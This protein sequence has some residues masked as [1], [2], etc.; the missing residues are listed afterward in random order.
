LVFG[1]PHSRYGQLPCAQIILKEDLS[2]H[3]LRA[4]C[5]KIL[6]PYKVPKEFNIV[7]ELS[8]TKSGKLVR[9]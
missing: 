2:V 5:L 6:S 9:Y 7:G 1:E 4:Y 3:D 8:L